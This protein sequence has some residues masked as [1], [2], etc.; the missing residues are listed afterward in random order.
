MTIDTPFAI[1]LADYRA[2][3]VAEL[4]RHGLAASEAIGVVRRQADAVELGVGMIPAAI[5]AASILS[6]E[7]TT[8]AAV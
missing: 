1:Q 4:R 8:D 5:V 7:G 2:E 6:L 3:V